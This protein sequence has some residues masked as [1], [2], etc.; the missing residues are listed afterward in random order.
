MHLLFR[1]NQQDKIIDILMNGEHKM[2]G[3]VSCVPTSFQQ[4]TKPEPFPAWCGAHRLEIALQNVYSA[5]G[6]ELFYKSLTTFIFY[7]CL[8]FSLQTVTQMKVPAVADK[9]WET[10][11]HVFDWFVKNSVGV[12]DHL[13][14]KT[15]LR[16]ICKVADAGRGRGHLSRPGE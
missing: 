9:R 6:G 16:A 15:H 12:N 13:D 2:T 1:S 5:L 8:Q 11:Y 10:M 4:V 7:L 14:Q 3:H